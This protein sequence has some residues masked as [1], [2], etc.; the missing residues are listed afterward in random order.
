MKLGA[1]GLK[2]SYLVSLS[3]LISMA[4]G[5]LNLLPFVFCGPLIFASRN[6]A[7]HAHHQLE[8]MLLTTAIGL[9]IGSILFI[10]GHSFFWISSL[11]LV[12]GGVATALL[13]S[14]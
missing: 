4:L 9:F 5:N 3:T 2:I 11:W 7:F 8:I 13:L 14:L 6:I 1:I 10:K 12:L